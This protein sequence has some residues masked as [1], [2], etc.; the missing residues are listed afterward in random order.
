MRAASATS[1]FVIAAGACL[2][3]VFGCNEQCDYSDEALGFDV[4]IADADVGP[5][6]SWVDADVAV[7]CESVCG[8]RAG[9][10]GANPL[11]KCRREIIDGGLWVACS[12]G[13]LACQE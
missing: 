1:C 12:F 5:D 4:N 6:A 3:H 10:P 2:L 7:P 8:A 11:T 13:G 9:G